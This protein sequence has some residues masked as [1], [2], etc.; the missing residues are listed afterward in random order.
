MNATEQLHDLGQSLWLD[1]IT[2][3]LLN[4]GTLK[5]YITEL[6]VTGLTSNP[7]IFDHAISGSADYD[8]DI[9]RLVKSGSC[10][11]RPF[12]RTGPAGPETGGP[13]F[14][15]RSRTHGGGGRLGFPGSLA[16]AG[17]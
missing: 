14:C 5:R 15:C 3:Q 4:S 12:F 9:R 2:R 10:R 11:R 16:A 8:E 7:T 1:H 17:L 6:S 13:E